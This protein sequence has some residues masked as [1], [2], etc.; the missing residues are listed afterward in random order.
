MLN[1]LK[2]NFPSKIHLHQDFLELCKPIYMPMSTSEELRRQISCLISIKDEDR[3]L[4]LD[5]LEDAWH[6][7]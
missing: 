3:P 7:L 2:E 1:I 6:I 5:E 4:T